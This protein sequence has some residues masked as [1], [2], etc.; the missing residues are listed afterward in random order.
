[1]DYEDQLEKALGETPDI[2]GTDDRLDVPDTTVR[3]EGRVTV[4]E[5]FQAVCRRLDRNP[6][7]V[8]KYLQNEMGT[9]GHVDESGRAR[10]TGEFGADRLD[11]AIER[12]V[13]GFVRCPECGLPDTRLETERGTEIRRCEA[14]G[15]RTATGS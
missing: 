6:Q 4:F 12:Y 7:H 3:Q 14:C 8:M 5:N 15:A 11:A 9:S 1:M 2:E 13:E 10:L